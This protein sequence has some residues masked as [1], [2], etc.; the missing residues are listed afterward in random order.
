MGNPL[1]Q[2]ARS[3][4]GFGFPN[5]DK[6]LGEIERVAQKYSP[7]DVR[8]FVQ[9]FCEK[10]KQSQ[11]ADLTEEMWSALDNSDSFAVPQN[12]WDTIEDLINSLNEE[13]GS[14]RDWKKFKTMME[15]GQKVDAPILLKRSGQLHKVSG[16]TRLM[17]AR[18]MGRTP[19]VLVVEV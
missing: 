7:Q 2:S 19:K 15:K 10:A 16:N 4:A 1:E 11:L 13:T 3:E 14:T 18:A 9:A 5:I 12:G 8:G 6:E 17:V